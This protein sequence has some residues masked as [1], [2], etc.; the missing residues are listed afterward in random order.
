M[1]LL[2]YFSLYFCC[3][4]IRI[5]YGCKYSFHG[6][7]TLNY[8]NTQVHISCRA[9][10]VHNWSHMIMHVLF[11]ILFTHSKQW[12]HSIWTYSFRM[13]RCASSKN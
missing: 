1:K 5:K 2:G 6:K 11:T 8:R 10:Y 13:F 7:E 12:L 4:S 9:I 3:S